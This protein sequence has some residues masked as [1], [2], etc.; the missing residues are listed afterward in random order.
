MTYTFI[1]RRQVVECSELLPYPWYP[2]VLAVRWRVALTFHEFGDCYHTE[3]FVHALSYMHRLV[4]F[5]VLWVQIIDRV[6]QG[7]VRTYQLVSI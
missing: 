6:E 3:V 4:C 7:I 5:F 2:R 1:E